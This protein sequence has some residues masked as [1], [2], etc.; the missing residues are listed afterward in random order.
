MP[1]RAIG[2]ERA[3]N[4]L[5]AARVA[6][7]TA[8]AWVSLAISKSTMP[9]LLGVRMPRALIGIYEIQREDS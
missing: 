1:R 5:A 2:H 4:A 7:R 6:G 8:G 3:V 9:D